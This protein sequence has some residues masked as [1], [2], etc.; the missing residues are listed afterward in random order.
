MGTILRL[1]GQSRPPAQQL[2]EIAV[3]VGILHQQGAD[4]M[5]AVKAAL[6]RAV[7]RRI[8]G[9]GFKLDDLFRVLPKRF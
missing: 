5:G 6:P 2:R 3:D 8:S 1:I 7:L 4:E 9:G